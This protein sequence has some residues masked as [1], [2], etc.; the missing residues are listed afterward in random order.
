[1]HMTIALGCVGITYLLVFLPKLPVPVAQAKQPG[2]YDN[3]NPRDQHAKL[4]GWAKR[5]HAAH[6][7]G[8]ESFAPFAAAVFVATLGGG[9]PGW[10]N[11]LALVHVGARA[12]Y[13][14][15]YMA[16]LAL[17]RSTVWTVGFLATVAL[18]ALP[19]FA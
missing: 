10:T 7:N 3:H 1:M 14:F 6:L 15:M 11:I 17:L 16:D 18:F 9:D 13:P 19:I 2:G 12:L 5:A 4:T 8:F